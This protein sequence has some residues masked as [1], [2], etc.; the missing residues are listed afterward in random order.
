MRINDYRDK[1][2]DLE[3]KRRDLATVNDQY[4]FG[5]AKTIL[6]KAIADI[7][8]EIDALGN[9]VVIPAPTVVYLSVNPNTINLAVGATQQLYVT[10]TMSDGSSKDV[11]KL[12]HAYNSF[13][14]GDLLANS[15]KIVSVNTDNY[16]GTDITYFLT[17]AGEGGWQVADNVGTKGMYALPTGTANEFSIKLADGTDTGVRFTTDGNEAV[18]DNY[19]IKVRVE[20]NGTLYAVTDDT[21]V[22]VSEEGLVTSLAAGS[23]TIYIVN[24]DATTVATATVTL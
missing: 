8:A 16:V 13:V 15:G 22:S 5:Y 14:D 11:T 10:A 17:F 2:I 3:L 23:T 9:L 12:K 7:D 1:L 19:T 21:I 6:T 24:G 20:T 4:A 18:Q